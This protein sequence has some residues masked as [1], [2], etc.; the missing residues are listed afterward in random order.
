[1]FEFRGLTAR[2]AG[3]TENR[4]KENKGTSNNKHSWTVSIVT[5]YPHALIQSPDVATHMLPG[6]APPGSM[7]KDTSKKTAFSDLKNNQNCNI[8]PQQPSKS[9]NAK[10]S[11]GS[12]A[13]AL[14]AFKSTS[15][16]L[17]P[18]PV[19]GLTPMQPQLKVRTNAVTKPKQTPR[20][21]FEDDNDDDYGGQPLQPIDHHEVWAKRWVLNDE[22]IERLCTM[23]NAPEDPEPLLPPPSFIDD[24]D[25]L[26]DDIAE[27]ELPELD[28]PDLP[29]PELDMSFDMSLD[30]SGFNR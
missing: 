19:T 7:R 29:L 16:I 18:N 26:M 24:D 5:V 9:S 30:S 17:P 15:T 21:V 4:S 23:Q 2:M 8:T 11:F 6:K 12:S 27:P 25:L 13:F 3:A 1:M 22:Q 10:L 14:S 28:W 20:F